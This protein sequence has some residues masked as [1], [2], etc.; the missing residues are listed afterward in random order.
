MINP[1]TSAARLEIVF[2]QYS[3]NTEI[4]KIKQRFWKRTFETIYNWYFKKKINILA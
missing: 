3:L 4:Q 2:Q 1:I